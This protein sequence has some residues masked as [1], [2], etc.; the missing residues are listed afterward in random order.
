[1][2]T[3]VRATFF[4]AIAF[5]STLGDTLLVICLPLGL[6][7][8]T[9]NIS[10]A[11]LAW[12]IP[13]I[14]IFLSS[15]LGK[16]V[17]K[18]SHTERRDYALILIAIAIIE[19]IFGIIIFTVT[20]QSAMLIVISL[21]VFFYAIAKEGITRLI[22]NVS[23]YKFFCESRTYLRISGKKAALDIVAGVVG[24]IIASQ[25]ISAGEWRYALIL[26]A[27]TFLIFGGGVLLIGKD[28]RHNETSSNTAYINEKSVDNKLIS[29][30]L[31]ILFGMPLLHGV[32]ALYAYFQ[33]LIIDKMQIMSV[34]TSIL[35]LSLIRLP[36]LIAGY[37]FDKLTHF[38]SLRAVVFLFPLTYVLASA[39]FIL[40]P[41]VYT[42]TF[43]MFMGGISIGIYNPS[44]INLINELTREKAVTVNAFML[45]CIGF[46]QTTGCVLSMIFYGGDELPRYQIIIA[47]LI[48]M[49]IGF[50]VAKWGANKLFF[51]WKTEKQNII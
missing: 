31:W 40:F 46:F 30:I 12:L 2:T 42:I 15:F 26:D 45:R 20:S 1:M 49:I 6:G 9:G 14:A 25:I 44:C 24:L 41:N 17:S 29:P 5:L 7:K 28:Y 8:E 32:N 27:I 35:F 16:V 34:S 10:F 22:Y 50:V 4:L 37:H 19:I 36:G 13:S 43:T 33:P 39:L 51:T 48:F 21:F 3:S 11:L 23:I 47:F 38:I 18:R